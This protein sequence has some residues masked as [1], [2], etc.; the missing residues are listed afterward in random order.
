MDV[1]NPGKDLI[2]AVQGAVKWFHA[3]KLEGIRV[4]VAVDK[5]GKKNT[6]IVKDEKAQGIWARFYLDR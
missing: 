2:N 1:E 5:D 4:D 6:T 3:N